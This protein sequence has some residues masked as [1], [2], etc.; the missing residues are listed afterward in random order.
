MFV[1]ILTTTIDGNDKAPR[2]G[3]SS[4]SCFF[5]MT[6]LSDIAC[7]ISKSHNLMSFLRVQMIHSG[8][9][10]LFRPFLLSSSGHDGPLKV[11][12]GRCE[13][14]LHQAFIEAGKQCGLGYT[15]DMN[16]YRQEG[17]G[18]MD[19]TIYNGVRQSASRAYLQPVIKLDTWIDLILFLDFAPG[20]LDYKRA[21]TDNEDPLPRQKSNWNR[22][23][24]KS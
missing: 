12:Q 6:A 5:N 11:M 1:V 14:P 16:G 18:P 22:I 17:C 21:F 13:H 19:M 8:K 20:E 23:P 3:L 7:H 4:R 9:T 24:Q 15:E 10:V 2:I